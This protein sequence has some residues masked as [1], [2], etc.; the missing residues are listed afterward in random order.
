MEKAY[1]RRCDDVDVLAFVF[2]AFDHP[3]NTS[4]E[5]QAELAQPWEVRQDLRAKYVAICINV[6]AGVAKIL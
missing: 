2:L 3:V 4:F 5:C 1:L 6:C